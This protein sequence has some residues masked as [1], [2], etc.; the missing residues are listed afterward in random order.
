LKRS[1]ARTDKALT[2]IDKLEKTAELS[3]ERGKASVLDEMKQHKEA[4]RSSPEIAAP[5]KLKTVD[6][7][8]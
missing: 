2:Q 5:R 3:A 4:T 1:L 7:E 6:Q 8:L